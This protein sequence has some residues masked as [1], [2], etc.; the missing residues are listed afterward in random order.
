MQLGKLYFNYKSVEYF[1][2]EQADLKFQKAIDINQD[3]LQ[4]VLNLAEIAI[5]QENYLAS[6]ERLRVVLGSDDKNIEAWFLMGFIDFKNGNKKDANTKFI[7]ACELAVPQNA[8]N[9]VTGEGDTKTGKSLER[10]INP[11]IFDEYF[12]NLQL[13]SAMEVEQFMQIRYT[14]LN[15]FIV[16]LQNI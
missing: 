14:Q 4:P 2:L 12:K 6:Q 16:E 3:F 5:I 15:N 7:K 11:S 13:D 1:N 8:E 10:G 9:G